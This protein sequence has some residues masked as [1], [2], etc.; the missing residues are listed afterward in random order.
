MYFEHYFRFKGGSSCFE[1]Q[2]QWCWVGGGR[3]GP[4]QHPQTFLHSKKKKREN[5]GKEETFSK[6]KLLKGCHQGQSVTHFAN[7]EHLEF[8]KFKTF[9][10][11]VSLFCLFIRKWKLMVYW[12]CTKDLFRG[13]IFITIHSLEM[14]TVVLIPTLI[15][16]DH[17][18]LLYS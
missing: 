1:Y 8:K 7:L 3:Q 14:R 17:I 6:Q 15:V 5:K 9:H 2:G 13:T 18:A 12:R 4:I 16:K 10:Y 11:F